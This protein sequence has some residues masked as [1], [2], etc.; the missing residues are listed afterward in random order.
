MEDP[1]YEF[2]ASIHYTSNVGK[3]LLDPVRME[4]AEKLLLDF[5]WWDNRKYRLDSLIRNQ[6][7]GSPLFPIL[8][9]EGSFSPCLG[10]GCITV[11]IEWIKAKKRWHPERK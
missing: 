9:C 6:A 11:G 7:K 5:V 8:I 2:L 3:T 4:L 1:R 10:Y